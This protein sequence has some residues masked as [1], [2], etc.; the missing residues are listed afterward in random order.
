MSHEISRLQTIKDAMR[1][2]Q[3][4]KGGRTTRRTWP[5]TK[6]VE[7]VILMRHSWYPDRERGVTR[8]I[9]LFFFQIEQ[10]QGMKGGGKVDLNDIVLLIRILALI[11]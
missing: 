9:D 5:K 8:N 2:E 11:I 4:K 6:N 3:K 10:K 7:L 1:N